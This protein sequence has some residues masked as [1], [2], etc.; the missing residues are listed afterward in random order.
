MIN[1]DWNMNNGINAETCKNGGRPVW[2]Y[3]QGVIL[4]A[5]VELNI[6]APDPS[7]LDTAEQIA[8]A[9]IR[10]LT[11]DNGVLHEP[12]EPN[13]GV[14]RPHF[15]WILVRG[16]GVLQGVGSRKEWRDGEG[17]DMESVGG[18]NMDVGGGEEEIKAEERDDREQMEGEKSEG[19]R[20][21][22]EGKEEEKKG[23]GKLEKN[24]R[25][26]I[27]ERANMRFRIGKR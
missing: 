9:A 8:F 25:Q 10:K 6:A 12:R 20:E 7:Y 19:E 15:K 2:T 21:D 17:K 23:N 22:A 18:E 14:D 11:D 27:G 1:A 3:N 13:L 16:L 5:L 4:G 24:E 26:S